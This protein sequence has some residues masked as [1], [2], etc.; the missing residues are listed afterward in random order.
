MLDFCLENDYI[1]GLESLRFE[2][3]SKARGSLT[4]EYGEDGYSKIAERRL[5]IVDRKPSVKRLGFLVKL[6]RAHVGCLGTGRR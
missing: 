4:I 5:V 3:G 1:L 2:V 6:L